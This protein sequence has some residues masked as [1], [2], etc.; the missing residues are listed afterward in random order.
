MSMLL[1]IATGLFAGVIALIVLGISQ[2][3]RG[4]GA[5]G[6]VV[7]ITGAGC[8]L[9]VLERL[10]YVILFVQTFGF[11]SHLTF[12]EKLRSPD[13]NS[14]FALYHDY[15]G[16]GDPDWHV[17]KIPVQEA[18]EKVKIPVSYRSQ[19]PFVWKGRMLMWNWSEAGDHTSNPHLEMFNGR[20][21]VFVRGSYYHGLYDIRQDRT[22]ITDTS[23]WH[24]LVYSAE[25]RQMPPVPPGQRHELMDKWVAE[26]LH[27]PIKAIINSGR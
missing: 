16:I 7:M 9:I 18:P 17:F 13:G 2:S 26:T 27:N 14:W 25:Y 21:L 8:L 11:Q 3:G 6:A 1:I 22:L 19:R 10:L 12:D 4:G 15:G 5:L 20:Y 23:P 24:S